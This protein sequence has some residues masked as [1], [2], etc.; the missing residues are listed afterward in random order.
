MRRDI[1]GGEGAIERCAVNTSNRF[2]GDDEDFGTARA[3]QRPDQLA[4]ARQQALADQDVVAAVRQVD[5][6]GSDLA[7]HSNPIASRM[8]FTA[9]VAGPSPESIAMSASA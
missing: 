2:I 6:D 4:G 1:D 5:P 8:A 7:R 9:S 3:H